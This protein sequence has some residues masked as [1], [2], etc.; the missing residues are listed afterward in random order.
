MNIQ[1]VRVQNFRSIEDE[2]LQCEQLTV[3]VGAN[4]CGKSAFL[5]AVE[6]F[7]TPSPK[8]QPDDFY[9]RDTDRDIVAAV[10]FTASFVVLTPA[11]VPPE[12]TPS[13]R[14]TTL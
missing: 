11:K 9:N 7:Y 10:T 2:T 8:V 1:S 5:R 12:T 13:G 6:L 3:L 14:I 4:G